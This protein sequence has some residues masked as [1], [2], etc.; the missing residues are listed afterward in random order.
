MVRSSSASNRKAVPAAWPDAASP[1]TVP[2]LRWEILYTADKVDPPLTAESVNDLAQSAY[3]L[4]AI[5]ISVG[6]I[7]LTGHLGA[8]ILARRKRAAETYTPISN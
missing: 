8:Y 3:V 1:E 4:G 2:V 6:A 7:A 5:G